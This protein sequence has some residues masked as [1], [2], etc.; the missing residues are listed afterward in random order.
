MR[1]DEIVGF[2]AGGDDWRYAHVVS[3]AVFEATEKAIDALKARPARKKVKTEEP[4]VKT[5]VPHVKTEE[6]AKP[7]AKASQEA[8]K[9]PGKK[10]AGKHRPVKTEFVNLASDEETEYV[11]PKTP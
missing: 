2:E 11:E 8:K 3:H 7:E 10:T 6:P 9:E 1:G 5:E 4:H